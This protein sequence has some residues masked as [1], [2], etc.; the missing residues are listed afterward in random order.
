MLAMIRN[1]HNIPDDQKRKSVV[2]V[3]SSRRGS[4]SGVL[5]GGELGDIYQ[6]VNQ[7]QQMIRKMSDASDIAPLSQSALHQQLGD[8]TSKPE[9]PSQGSISV[10]SARSLG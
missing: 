7:M 10:N 9:N 3:G 5:P 2:S 4:L 6:T 1:Y 8:S